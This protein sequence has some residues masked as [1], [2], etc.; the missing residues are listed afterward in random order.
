MYEQRV[1]V[2][3]KSGLHARPAHLFAKLAMTF[4]AKISVAKGDKK[5][6]AKSILMVLTLG[7]N[8]GTEITLT[9]EGPDERQAV[10]ALVELIETGLTE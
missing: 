10:T 9:A 5:V 6:D 4:Q 7:V 1:V 8:A 3:N 2:N